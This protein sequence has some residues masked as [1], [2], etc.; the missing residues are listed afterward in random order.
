MKPTRKKVL[1]I[2]LAVYAVLIVVCFLFSRSLLYSD[3][4][5]VT[6]GAF[7]YGNLHK[8]Y[9]LQG[10]YQA[11]FS[12]PVVIDPER[13]YEAIVTEVCATPGSSL[14]E[15]GCPVQMPRIPGAPGGP[16]QGQAGAGYR[17]PRAAQDAVG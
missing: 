12:T 11:E 3:T 9:T 17:A 2:L 5:R 1:G 15:G 13:Q 7:S 10:S 4:P 8:R 16:A 14:G 6:V